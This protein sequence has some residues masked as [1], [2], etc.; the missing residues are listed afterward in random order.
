[1]TE[2]LTV[3]LNPA[4]DMATATP[5]V[6]AEGKLRCAAPLTEPG[7]GGANVARALTTLGARP[8]AWIAVGGPTGR[9][10][11]ERFEA[12]GIAACWFEAPGDTR[13]TL[14]VT[15]TETGG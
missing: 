4:L 3:T 11:R 10:Y 9:E 5:R 12:E 2:L 15:E 8:R 14:G 6:V 13:R 7:G 1:M